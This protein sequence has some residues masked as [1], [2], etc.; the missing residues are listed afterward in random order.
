MT[1]LDAAARV[2]GRPGAHR[3]ANFIVW[4]GPCRRESAAQSVRLLLSRAL[5]R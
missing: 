4:N 2:A 5:G 1:V 3:F